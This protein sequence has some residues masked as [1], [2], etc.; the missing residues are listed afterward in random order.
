MEGQPL[1]T[2][3]GMLIEHTF[4]ADGEYVFDIGNLATGGYV[5]NMDTKHRVLLTIDGLKVFEASL[6]GEADLKAIDQSQPQAA[7]VEAINARFKNIR[8][9]VKVRHSKSGR[10]FCRPGLPDNPM[11]S[12]SPSFQAAVWTAFPGF[13]SYRS[14][15][16]TLRPAS[17]T[18]QAVNEFSS[19][20]RHLAQSSTEETACATKILRNIARQAYRRPVTDEDLASPLTFFK[21]ARATGSFDAGI[22]SALTLILSSPKFLYRTEDVPNNAA[23]G[24]VFPINDLELASRLSFFLWSQGPDDELLEAAATGKLKTPAVLEK[25]MRRMLKDS[26]SHAMAE[27]FAFQWLNLRS[28]RE[29]D[30]DPIVFPNFDQSLKAAFTRELDL[31]IESIID[32]DRNV[33]DLLVADHTFVNERLALHYGIPNIRGDRFRRVTLTDPNRFGLLGK[34]G[35]L[36]VTSYPNRT[37]PCCAAHGFW[38]DYSA[39]RRRRL[40]RTWKPSRKMWREK[41]H[42]RSENGWKRTGRT[43]HAN[44]ATSSWILS[45]SRWRISTPSARGAHTD[46]YSGTPIDAAGQLVDGTHVNNPSELRRA[47]AANPEQFVQTLTEKLLM[48]S[49]GRT[50][51]YH[52]MPLVR[53]IVRDAAR[54]GYRFSS[55]VK[56]IVESAPF[57]QVQISGSA[58]G[59]N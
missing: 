30:P 41:R 44:R 5:L 6:G 59:E 40:R 43:R 37:A 17:A 23:P 18:H 12:S 50:V 53:R 19:V 27:N 54:D 26:K 15:A 8:I 55:I 36:M 45:G 31:F 28:I 33:T 1:G 38:R 22:E 11:P 35:I 7:A 49:L 56:G 57:Q 25:Q 3:G 16:R 48:Y 32:E 39:L 20:R 47:L 14:Q 21:N 51:E 29:F 13:S 52:D 58:K 46:R 24:A 2:R 9:G 10:D 4:P 34:G 42:A